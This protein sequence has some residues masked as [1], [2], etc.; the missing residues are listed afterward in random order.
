MTISVACYISNELEHIT[1][2]REKLRTKRIIVRNESKKQ[3][4]SVL[5]NGRKSCCN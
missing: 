5:R 1:D 3:N 4:R 2:I